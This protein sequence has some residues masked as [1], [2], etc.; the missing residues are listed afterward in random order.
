MAYPFHL[1]AGYQT[2]LNAAGS[3]FALNY[4]SRGRGEVQLAC[5]LSIVVV[6]VASVPEPVWRHSLQ[7]GK[8]NCE[9]SSLALLVSVCLCLCLA[10]LV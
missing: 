6:V 9:S 8:R 2:K 7:S 3:K 5:S 1:R 4:F 10:C